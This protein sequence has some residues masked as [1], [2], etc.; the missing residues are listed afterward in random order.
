MFDFPIFNYVRSFIYIFLVVVD[1]SGIG[2]Y[3]KDEYY[4]EAQCLKLKYIENNYKG[5]Y[6]Y[7]P[8]FVL[9]IM[10]N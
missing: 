8:Q 9:M 10:H 2:S 4:Y 3:I 7:F 1:F 6:F 5:E